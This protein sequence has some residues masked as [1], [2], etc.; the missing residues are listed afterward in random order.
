MNNTI[1]E[2]NNNKH[3]SYALMVCYNNDLTD[4][5]MLEQSFHPIE[6]L[7]ELVIIDYQCA[8]EN[9]LDVTMMAFND[10]VYCIKNNVDDTTS[11][12]FAKQI[13]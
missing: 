2:K 5:I 6:R 12:Y 9:N 10:N 13:S 11:I 1:H 3:I 4:A 8:I 7:L